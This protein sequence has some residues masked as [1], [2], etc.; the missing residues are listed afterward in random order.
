[1]PTTF[2]NFPFLALSMIFFLFG[3]AG[4]ADRVAGAQSA[5]GFQRWEGAGL[6]KHVVDTFLHVLRWF[7]ADKSLAGGRGAIRGP[8][9]DCE[10]ALKVGI[11]MPCLQRAC[12]PKELFAVFESRRQIEV[13][14]EVGQC[15]DVGAA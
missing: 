7:A 11:V 2:L 5:A 13:E 6:C 8:E 3:A 9:N 10:S 14:D 1:M 15:F 4:C 12:E